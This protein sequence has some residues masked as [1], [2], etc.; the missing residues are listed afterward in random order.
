MRPTRTMRSPQATGHEGHRRLDCCWPPGFRNSLARRCVAAGRCRP[1]GSHNPWTRRGSSGRRG[2]LGPPWVA[3]GHGAVAGQR[4]LR[5]RPTKTARRRKARHLA[6]VG[7]ECSGR[8]GGALGARRLARTDTESPRRLCCSAR[9]TTTSS[10]PASSSRTW[11][12]GRFAQLGG[13]GAA[14]VGSALSPGTAAA[15]PR[16]FVLSASVSACLFLTLSRPFRAH[17]SV[18]SLPLSLPP[19][20]AGAL[21]GSQRRVQATYLRIECGRLRRPAKGLQRLVFVCRL[22]AATC[23]CVH[24]NVPPLALML[25]RARAH[26]AC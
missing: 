24:T 20:A 1:S 23:V 18:A 8:K 15:S 6:T 4:P 19:L 17:S 11:R 12:R 10:T 9:G 21:A 13:L 2:P 26:S 14:R 7:V 25:L 5:E 3:A 22:P 16:A